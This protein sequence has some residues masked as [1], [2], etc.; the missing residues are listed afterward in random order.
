[1]KMKF[2]FTYGVYVLHI[3][4]RFLRFSFKS[5]LSL[6]RQASIN[7]LYHKTDL[8]SDFAPTIVAT[9]V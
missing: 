4:C 3:Y 9:E 1:M 7:P 2:Y 5:R 8:H 6:R